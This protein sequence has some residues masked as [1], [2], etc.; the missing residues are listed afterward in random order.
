MVARDQ[1]RGQ[2][3]AAEIRQRAPQGSV[4]LLVADLASQADVRRLAA[5]ILAVHDRV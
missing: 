5:Q 4:E 2:A 3:A 1:E